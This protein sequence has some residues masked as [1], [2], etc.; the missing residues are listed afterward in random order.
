MEVFVL[1][2]E[3]TEPIYLEPL[4]QAT[5]QL[6]ADNH[7][8]RETTE[9]VLRKGESPIPVWEVDIRTLRVLVSSMPGPGLSFAAY[10]FLPSLKYPVRIR[11]DRLLAEDRD[12]VLVHTE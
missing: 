11:L 10:C 2:A 8:G 4:D 9:I 12:L 3:I 6:I 1:K 7:I 5:N